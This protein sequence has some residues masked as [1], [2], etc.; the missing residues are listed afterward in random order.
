MLEIT[1][2]TTIKPIL[3]YLSYNLKLF[4]GVRCFSET[5]VETVCEQKYFMT[6]ARV[7][8]EKGC[9]MDSI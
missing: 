9:V 2:F 3:K 6:I 8:V 5:F 4:K 1:S 7:F